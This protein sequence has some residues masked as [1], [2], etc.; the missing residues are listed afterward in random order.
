[1]TKG[2]SV[3]KAFQQARNER[4][5]AHRRKKDARRATRRE[6][7]LQ[8]APGAPENSDMDISATATGAEAPSL[9][10]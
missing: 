8:D 2:G 4:A 10:G 7:S 1:M 9:P 3:K 6:R 5:E